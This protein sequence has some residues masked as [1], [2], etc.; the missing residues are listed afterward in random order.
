MQNITPKEAKEL[1]LEAFLQDT[2][3]EIE[4]TATINRIKD[5]RFRISI[6]NKYDFFTLSPELISEITHLHFVSPKEVVGDILKTMIQNVKNS[7]I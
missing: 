3:K 7:V 6:N 1:E 5:D 2:L 4:T